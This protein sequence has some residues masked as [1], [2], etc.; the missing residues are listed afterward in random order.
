[1]NDIIGLNPELQLFL[2]L[3]ISMLAFYLFLVVIRFLGIEFYNSSQNLHKFLQDPTRTAAKGLMFVCLG[4][5]GLRGWT[6]V[7]RFGEQQH[8]DLQFMAHPPWLIIPATFGGL[9]IIG[10]LC[11]SRALIENRSSW[12]VTLV[13]V[14]F[15]LMVTLFT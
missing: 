2:N 9:E 11:A 12:E 1:M 4:E 3:S 6:W 7:A 10:L 5:A 13:L 8:W 15:S 14:I